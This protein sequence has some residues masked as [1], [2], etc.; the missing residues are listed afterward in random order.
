MKEDKSGFWE[1]N[2]FHNNTNPFKE[3]RFSND[4]MYLPE[5]EWEKKDFD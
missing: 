4:D 3:K 5:D 2:G 1:S